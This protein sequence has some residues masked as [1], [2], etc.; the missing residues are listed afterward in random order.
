MEGDVNMVVAETPSVSNVMPK[1][2]SKI[3]GEHLRH[4]KPFPLE[5][6]DYQ[7]DAMEVMQKKKRILNR[8]KMGLGKTVVSTYASVGKTLVAAP[9]YLVEQWYQWLNGVTKGPDKHPPYAPYGRQNIVWCTG[10]YYQKLD[11]LREDADFHIINMEMFQTHADELIAMA[12]DYKWQTLI[13]DESHHYR[14]HDAQRSKAMVE[15]ACCVEYMYEL[16]GSPIW[17]EV[18][19][20]FMQFRALQPEIFTSYYHFV[21]QFCIA[22]TTRFGTKVLGVKKDQ[23]P[24]LDKILKVL[25]VHAD[26]ESAKRELPPVITKIVPVEFPKEIMKA[27][28]DMCDTFRMQFMGEDIR[29]ENFSQILRTMRL[30][31]AFPGKLD[32]VQQIIE[33]AHDSSQ[34][35][36][37]FSWYRETCEALAKR[38]KVPAI[39]GG[40]TDI[41]ERRRLALETPIVCATLASLSEGIDLSDARTVIYAEEHYTSGSMEQSLGRIVR[42]RQKANN[43]DPV[44]LYYVH[45]KDTIDEVIHAKVQRR[46]ATIKEILKESLHLY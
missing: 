15:V 46:G 35:A 36:V 45:V 13:V 10:N 39:H 40:I 41:S 25:S 21:D 2:T 32:A 11:C 6:R 37:I 26:Y 18:D 22:D 43:T 12:N 17:K 38:F 3:V 20:L 23:T 1:S 30:L 27:Y 14:N 8:F 42:E 33:D 5:P 44:L 9:N 28:Q 4:L 16:S 29:F 31:T 19:D 34:R 24:E 7:W